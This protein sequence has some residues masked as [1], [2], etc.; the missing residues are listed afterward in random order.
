MIL[1]IWKR[2]AEQYLAESGIP[3]TI[4]RQSFQNLHH[5][6][7]SSFLQLCFN[8][9]V[10][11]FGFTVLCSSFL[12]NGLED[13]WATVIP[14]FQDPNA[15]FLLYFQYIN[16]EFGITNVVQIVYDIF[17]LM[18][19]NRATYTWKYFNLGIEIVHLYF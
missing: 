18:Q 11:L 17:A 10:H 2:K 9:S 1:Q 15:E 16:S 3:Y 14:A 4:I 13:V 5:T 19:R 6:T 7:H 12:P 8:R